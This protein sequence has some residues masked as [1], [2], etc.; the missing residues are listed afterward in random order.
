MTQTRPS[1]KPKGAY[2]ADGRPGAGPPSRSGRPCRF[3]D[4]APLVCDHRATARPVTHPHTFEYLKSR[5]VMTS[6]R[7]FTFM[8][9]VTIVLVWGPAPARRLILSVAVPVPTVTGASS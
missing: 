9:T 1:G 4:S 5:Q 7:S 2:R 3:L 8:H 6:R